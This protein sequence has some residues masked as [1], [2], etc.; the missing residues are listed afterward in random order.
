M[1]KGRSW[2]IQGMQSI[3]DPWNQELK[4]DMRKNMKIPR[5][6]E[7]IEKPFIISRITR[8]PSWFELIKQK[9]RR[10]NGSYDKKPM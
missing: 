3:K 7:K 6:K 2:N 9:L 1:M 10:R 5:K 4:R 8:L